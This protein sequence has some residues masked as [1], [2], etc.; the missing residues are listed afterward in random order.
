MKLTVLVILAIIASVACDEETSESPIAVLFNE[1]VMIL[2]DSAPIAMPIKTSG[3]LTVGAV[4]KGGSS[5]SHNDGL[6]KVKLNNK[7]IMKTVR[8]ALNSITDLNKSE[9]GFYWTNIKLKSAYKRSYSSSFEH[10]VKFQVED[11]TCKPGSC[12]IECK[13]VVNYNPSRIPVRKLINSDC[14]PV[15]QQPIIYY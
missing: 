1:P 10:H 8:F 6:E 11:R 15:E 14:S 7:S 5:S 12:L 13:A 9:P 4:A 3:N 2:D